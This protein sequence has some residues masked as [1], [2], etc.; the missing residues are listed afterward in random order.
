MKIRWRRKK[1]E[2]KTERHRKLNSLLKPDLSGFL[3]FNLDP[4][5]SPENDREW[6]LL[7]IPKEYFETPAEKV[8]FA[9]AFLTEKSEK[10]KKREMERKQKKSWRKLGQPKFVSG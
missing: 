4:K 8:F 1:N 2:I 10:E 5:F 3:F 7:A 9:N 6:L